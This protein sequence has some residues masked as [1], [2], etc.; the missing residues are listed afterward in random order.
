MSRFDDLRREITGNSW[1][2]GLARDSLVAA[3]ARFD[4]VRTAGVVDVDS[5]ALTADDCRILSIV[6]GFRDTAEFQVFARRQQRKHVER[7]LAGRGRR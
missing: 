1:L 5:L 6:F 3:A 2:D 4:N 7:Q